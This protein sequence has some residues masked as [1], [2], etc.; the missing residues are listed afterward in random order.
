MIR[1]IGERLEEFSNDDVQV[2]PL[3]LTKKQIDKYNPPPNPAKEA[4]P[5]AMWYIRNYGNTSW[6][7]DA[8]N[9]K[10][11]TKLITDAVE[12]LID[13]DKYDAVI[14]QEEKNKN[15]IRKAF[16]IKQEQ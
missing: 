4:D 2:K 16:K 11:L 8:L 13:R 5:R 1:D 3:A 10:V 12:D 7:V 15:I 14:E 9:P 6:E